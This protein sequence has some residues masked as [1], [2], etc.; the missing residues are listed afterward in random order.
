MAK[1]IGQLWAENVA[2]STKATTNTNVKPVV[3]E[4]T[5]IKKSR[6][7]QNLINQNVRGKINEQ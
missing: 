7:R 4:D 2:K 5:D 1:S 3:D 6:Y